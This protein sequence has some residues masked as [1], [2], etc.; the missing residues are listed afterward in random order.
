MQARRNATLCLIRSFFNIN[1]SHSFNI[2]IGICSIEKITFKAFKSLHIL[3]SSSNKCIKCCSFPVPSF[4]QEQ[5]S[6]PLC[7]ICRCFLA[8]YERAGSCF[9]VSFTRYKQKWNRCCSWGRWA[10]GWCRSVK[11]RKTIFRVCSPA[12]SYVVL[13]RSAQWCL[14]ANTSMLTCWCSLFIS[15][16]EL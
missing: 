4:L 10:L 3:S 11:S 1:I 6:L 12:S 15:V 8:A 2:F 7:T 16:H 14:T 13:C 5:S 9:S